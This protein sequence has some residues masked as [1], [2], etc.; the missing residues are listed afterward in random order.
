MRREVNKMKILAAA[1]NLLLFTFIATAVAQ[2]EGKRPKPIRLVSGEYIPQ[3][4]SPRQVAPI[5]TDLFTGRY[6][7]LI[8]F[9][10]SP[11]DTQR[12]I[13]A[14]AGLD[15]V[16]YLPDDT[17]FAVIDQNFDL[18]ELTDAAITIIDV[19]AL[20]KAEAT[21]ADIQGEKPNRLTVSYYNTL[22]S[23]A[24][25]ANLEAQGVVVDNHRDY[26]RQLDI[27]IDP[28]Q[29]EALIALPYLQFIGAAPAEGVVE[30][31]NEEPASQD[32]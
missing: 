10:Q 19:L 18:S 26:A 22:D 2:T 11:D 5:A 20:F 1:S 9:T 31:A 21:L 3:V 8:Q 30:G 4:I 28:T 29:Y 14:N 13:W 27:R 24:V 12:A 7:K 6:F 23:N 32:P 17:Y 15:L 25:I 16:D